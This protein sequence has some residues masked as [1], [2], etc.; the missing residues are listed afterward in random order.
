MVRRKRC[1]RKECKGKICYQNLPDALEA[2]WE[3]QSPH[4]LYPYTCKSGHFHL[5]R[6]SRTKYF[7]ETEAY[8]IHRAM[9]FKS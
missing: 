1:K 5:S 3:I 9:G 2:S 7:H 8:H 6:S 4:T